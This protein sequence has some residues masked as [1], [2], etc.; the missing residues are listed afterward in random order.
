MSLSLPEFLV[1]RSKSSKAQKTARDHRSHSDHTNR[2][3]ICS[4]VMIC[5]GQNFLNCTKRKKVDGTGPD[6]HISARSIAPGAADSRTFGHFIDR[7]SAILFFRI[8]KRISQAGMSDRIRAFLRGQI[9]DPARDPIEKHALAASQAAALLLA[10]YSPDDSLAQIFVRAIEEDLRKP[11]V[12]QPADM[13]NGGNLFAVGQ[14]W[15][16]TAWR[17][18]NAWR[19]LEMLGTTCRTSRPVSA[20]RILATRPR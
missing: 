16:P 15:S 5:S 20:P 3:R 12:R 10:K 9:G 14:T 17:Q 4:M 8:A 1:C 19:G 11:D 13:S 6:I 7:G 18:E 2:W